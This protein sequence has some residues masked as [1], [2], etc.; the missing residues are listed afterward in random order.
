MKPSTALSILAVF[1]LGIAVGY[2]WGLEAPGRICQPPYLQDVS[3]IIEKGE[4]P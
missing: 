4:M 3:G 1:A 2:L